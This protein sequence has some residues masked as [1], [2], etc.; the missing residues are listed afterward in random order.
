VPIPK[1][2]K[3]SDHKVVDS[4]Y[5]NYVDNREKMLARFD[6]LAKIKKIKPKKELVVLFKE[7]SYS[8]SAP[9]IRTLDTDYDNEWLL[10]WGD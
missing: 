3:A 6:D 5:W 10:K 7:L 2:Y 9:K 8:G 1:A 4:P